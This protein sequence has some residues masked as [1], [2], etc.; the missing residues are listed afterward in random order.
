MKID[1]T[2][3]PTIVHRIK[4]E[5]LNLI[6]S[7]K[8]FFSEN[9]MDFVCNE[10]KKYAIFK[11]KHDFSVSVDEM[12]VHFGILIQSGY[13]KVPS[14][15]LQWKTKGDTFNSL[16]SNS[17]SRDRFET[18]NR[19][20]HFNDNTKIY[21][22]NR[23]FVSQ[24]L[25]EPLSAFGHYSLKQFIRGKPIRFGF[26]FW[27]LTL[28]EGYILKFNPYCR[29]GGKLE[30]K[31]LGLSVTEKSCCGQVATNST[32][33]LDNYFNSLSLLEELKKHGIN[34]IGTIRCDL[35][36]KAPLQDLKKEK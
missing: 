34:C 35:V 32:V 9:F 13:A 26:K 27:C 11:G 17:M 28:S 7:F 12:Y 29:V 3:P 20:F 1:K 5:Q 31:S 16:V 4:E 10:T 21:L 33:Y 14:R 18:T 25:G 24:K 30:G 6:D 22:N 8:I 23:I 2:S 19:Y 36:D 15:R